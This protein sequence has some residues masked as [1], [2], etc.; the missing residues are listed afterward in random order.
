MALLVRKRVGG[1]HAAGHRGAESGGG[2]QLAGALE[3]GH[4]LLHLHLHLLLLLL[5]LKRRS[6]KEKIEIQQSVYS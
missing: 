4:L 1:A 3:L 2:E 6:G 5:H